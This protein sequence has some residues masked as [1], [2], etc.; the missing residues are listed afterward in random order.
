MRVAGK[1]HVQTQMY[2]QLNAIRCTPLIQSFLHGAVLATCSILRARATRSNSSARFPEPPRS[3]FTNAVRTPR[4]SPGGP[5]ATPFFMMFLNSLPKVSSR[6][7]SGDAAVEKSNSFGDMAP[8]IACFNRPMSSKMNNSAS[9]WRRSL[10]TSRTLALPSPGGVLPGPCESGFRAWRS[11]SGQP[12]IGPDES[13][14]SQRYEM[15]ALV[16]ACERKRP[17]DTGRRKE[18]TTRPPDQLCVPAN[19]RTSR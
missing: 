3:V 8:A 16:N 6:S 14:A 19:M 1:W 9:T 12:F 10:G 4:C 5:I 11:V 15:H 7:Y 2:T 17:T 13:A 18:S